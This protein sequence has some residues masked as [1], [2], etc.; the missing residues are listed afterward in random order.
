MSKKPKF[1][2]AVKQT[3]MAKAEQTRRLMLGAVTAVPFPGLVNDLYMPGRELIKIED[4]L[5]ACASGEL[6]D[7]HGFG[8]LSDGMFTPFGNYS[9]S[10]MPE[11]EEHEQFEATLASNWNL[12]DPIHYTPG[13]GYNCRPSMVTGGTLDLPTWATHIIWY[14]R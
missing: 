12:P 5:D 8:F 3:P 1:E 6:R 7:C 2:V 13:R 11:P 14:K 9:E 10:E 4:W